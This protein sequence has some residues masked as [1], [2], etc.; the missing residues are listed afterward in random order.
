[1]GK[2]T[3][4]LLKDKADQ[5]LGH[6]DSID[7]CLY[8]MDQLQEGRSK[9]IETMKKPLIESLEIVRILWMELKSRL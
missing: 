7:M 5:A 1:M 8:M 4:H 3:R 9:P 6:I 2:S